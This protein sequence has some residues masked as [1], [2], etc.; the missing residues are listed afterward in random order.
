MSGLQRSPPDSGDEE[1][2]EHRVVETDPTGRFERYALSLGKGAYKEVFKAFDNEEGVEVAW[3]QLRIDHFQRRDA[4]RIL[5]EIRILESLRNDNIINMFAAWI[6]KGPDG[7]DKVCF[8]T[9]LMTSGTLKSYIRKSKGPV[10]PK[11]LK[12]WCRQILSGLHYLHTRNPPIIHRDLKCENVFINGN[13]G[14]AKIGDLGLAVVKSKDH[15]SSV[16]G[17][18]EFMAPELYDEKY[19]E[20][21]DIWSFGLMVLEIVTKEYPYSECTNQAQIYKKVS[22]GIKPLS[23]QKV[24]DPETRDFIDLCT[25][26]D[27]RRRPSAAD[28][29]RHPFLLVTQN[30]TMSIGSVSDDGLPHSTE[31]RSVTS[32]E[33]P[34]VEEG[35]LGV[36]RQNFFSGHSSPHSSPHAS[37]ALSEPRTVDAETHT[38][39]IQKVGA[40]ANRA[41]SQCSVEA[42]E[43]H[44]DKEILLKMLYTVAGR[45]TQEIKF[46]FNF[47]EDTGDLV[48]S[49]M[50]G[51]NLIEEADQQ[52]ARQRLEEAINA[53]LSHRRSLDED[54]RKRPSFDLGAARDGYTLP[55]A[56][57][58]HPSHSLHGS[59]AT[60]PATLPRSRSPAMEGL[61]SQKSN[62]LP[63]ASSASLL[64]LELT[65]TRG[66]QRSASIHGSRNVSPAPGSTSPQVRRQVLEDKGA[67]SRAGQSRTAGQSFTSSIPSTASTPSSLSSSGS[68]PATPSGEFHLQSLKDDAAALDVETGGQASDHPSLHPPLHVLG[69]SVS[70]TTP[71]I[72]AADVILMADAIQRPSSA[73]TVSDMVPQRTVDA[74]S[75]SMIVG[76]FEMARAALNNADRGSSP[77]SQFVPDSLIAMQNAGANIPLLSVTPTTPLP[78]AGPGSRVDPA[79]H[80][81]LLELQELNLKGFGSRTPSGVASNG[82]FKPAQTISQIRQQATG[83][84]HANPWVGGATSGVAQRPMGVG[85]VASGGS[86]SMVGG[87][88]WTAP[89]VSGGFSGQPAPISMGKM[90]AGTA[91]RPFPIH[92]PPQLHIPRI[93]TGNV[94]GGGPAVMAC[95]G[96]D[97]GSGVVGMGAPPS[98][99]HLDAGPKHA[100]SFSGSLEA[101]TRSSN[102]IFELNDLD[103]HIQPNPAQTLASSSISGSPPTRSASST[104]HSQHGELPE[105]VRLRTSS[106]RTQGVTFGSS[107]P[108]GHPGPSL[109]VAA[110]TSRGLSGDTEAGR[111]SLEGNNRGG[112]GP[113]K[114]NLMD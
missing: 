80:Q 74:M 5:S 2:E 99:H 79:I 20:K 63:R 13:N 53:I 85:H 25:Q 28:L 23:M 71:M 1:D 26:F 60:S 109:P 10:R 96:K 75:Q 4:Q 106:N 92:V 8:I 64:S 98:S 76:D 66:L 33:A 94:A 59:R 32:G 22:S 90:G 67:G 49:E 73:P 86:A 78:E 11:V 45:P 19:D 7:K 48:V 110:Q 72:G 27:G 31:P 107:P 50:V 43:W 102:A 112:E 87:S 3:N 104:P 51:E 47:A 108:T 18:P 65:D 14:Q 101:S 56:A 12:S 9:E 62:T 21:V 30:S 34:W 17:T 105:S 29:L 82:G 42:V 37:P 55:P 84:S 89:A 114:L 46:P 88:G 44:G 70:A 35:L 113:A 68:R 97:G 15:V 93:V 83:V 81:K 91:G 24:T 39:H 69:R 77:L 103:F 41:G 52:L 111:R 61:L 16:L 6:Q 58:P 54:E 95:D 57:L 38:F 36:S 40:P 100:R